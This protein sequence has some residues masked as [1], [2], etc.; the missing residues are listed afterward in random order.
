MAI[1]DS[2]DFRMSGYDR[3]SSSH[4]TAE[5]GERVVQLYDHAEG[6]WFAYDV[7]AA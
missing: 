2:P 1:T 6:A 3:G 4:F 5:V 7:H